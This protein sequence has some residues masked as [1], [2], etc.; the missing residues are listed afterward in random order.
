MSTKLYM[1][2][3]SGQGDTE[4]KLVDK[5]TWD[6]INEAPS[7]FK[8]KSRQTSVHQCPASI[9]ERI[10]KA[11]EDPE[12]VP[13]ITIG[14]PDNDAALLS[15]AVE[16]DGEEASFF[17]MAAAMKFIRTHDIEIEDSYEGCIY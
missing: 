8:G 12:Y 1:L 6:W 14:S 9:L 10:R 15:P 16:I 13:C 11:Q 2:T 17:S 4:V 7:Y 5:E 3:L